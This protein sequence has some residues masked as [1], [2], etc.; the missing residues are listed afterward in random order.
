MNT[1]L[2]SSSKSIPRAY[3]RNVVHKQIQRGVIL[4]EHDSRTAVRSRV[5]YSALTL[6]TEALKLGQ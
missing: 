1:C 6:F 4:V 3:V 5:L 2:E